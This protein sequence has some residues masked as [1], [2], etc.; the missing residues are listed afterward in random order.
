MNDTP[1]R[2]W[3]RFGLRTLFTLFTI[4]ALWLGWNAYQINQRKELLR[5]LST[6][7]VYITYGTPPYPWKQLPTT[8]RL[9]GVKPI[10]EI[11]FQHTNWVDENGRRQIKSAFPE[12]D[13]N[14]D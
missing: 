10:Q 8:W 13:T 9:F 7:N 4:I 14:L 5:F 11:R 2:R 12:A 1:K 6:Q 3:P